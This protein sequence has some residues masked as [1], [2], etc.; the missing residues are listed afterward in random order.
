MP[1]R[2]EGRERIRTQRETEIGAETGVLRKLNRGNTGASAATGMR[3]QPMLRESEHLPPT[4]EPG[5]RPPALRN[6]GP[7]EIL[8]R[9]TTKTASRLPPKTRRRPWRSDRHPTK[10]LPRKPCTCPVHDLS[11]PHETPWDPRH[12]RRNRQDRRVYRPAQA[13]LR[14]R[15]AARCAR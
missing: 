12:Q 5:C 11:I 7:F 9:P 8:R 15:R 10:S 6:C 3:T 2:Q 1:F 14:W 4:R 13:P